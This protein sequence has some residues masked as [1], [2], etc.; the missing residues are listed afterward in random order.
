MIWKPDWTR[1][2]KTHVYVVPRQR[3]GEQELLA[4]ALAPSAVVVDWRK[5]FLDTMRE[6]QKRLNLT[7]AS[8]TA[9]LRRIGNSKDK[10]IL[11]LINT[12][13]MLA[14]FDEDERRRLWLSLRNDFPH[15]NGILLF[16]VLDAPQF[17]PDKAT[18]NDWQA[19]GR[20]F[21]AEKL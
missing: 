2:G 5:D 19:D 7:I 18:L 11:A 3:Y 9:R 15:L 10:R 1:R 17:L 21:Y 8:E 13:Y 20:L 16:T 4:Y 12:E 6:G 14:R